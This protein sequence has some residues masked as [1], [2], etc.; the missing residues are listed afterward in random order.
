MQ[1]LIDIFKDHPNRIRYVLALLGFIVVVGIFG[2][3]ADEVHEGDTLNFDRAVLVQLRANLGSPQLDA[4]MLFLT[5]FG[6]VLAISVITAV[7]AAFMWKKRMFSRA[8]VLLLSI[9]GI[10]AAVTILKLVFARERPSNI[11]ELVNET[12]FSFPS[13]HSMGSMGIALTLALLLWQTKWRIPVAIGA[14]VYV[15][16]VGFSRLY[17]GAHYPTDVAAGWVLA[18]GWVATVYAIFKANRRFKV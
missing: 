9:G 3:I 8:I 5:E 7:A 15:L 2:S 17:L 13:G 12:T 14:A 16:V 18:A 4:V 1:R 6:G 10:A 11:G